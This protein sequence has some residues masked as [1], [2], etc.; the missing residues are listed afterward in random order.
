VT[1]RYQLVPRGTPDAETLAVVGREPWIVAGPRYVLVGSPLQPDA[2]SLPVAASFLPWLGDVISSRLHADPGGVRYAAPGDRLSRPPNVDALESAS[3]GRI[4]LEGTTLEAPA[5]AGTYF[6]IQG[7]RRVGAL[8]VNPEVAESQLAR[9]PAND[10]G[11]HVTTAS[12]RVARTRD[13]WVR[14]AFSG[15]GRRSLIAPLLVLVVLILGAETLAA[16]AGGSAKQ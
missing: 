9:W 4:P 13:E 2:T 5:A 8:V 16:S 11:A 3:G 10:L 6:F 14:L 12:A 1:T 7:T 15:A